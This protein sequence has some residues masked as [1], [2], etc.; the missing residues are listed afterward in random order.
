MGTRTRRRD[1]RR[2]VSARYSYDGVIYYTQRQ[3]LGPV[4][5]DT[6]QTGPNIPGYRQVI[7]RGGDATTGLIGTR[8]GRPRFKSAY[9]RF[10]YNTFGPSEGFGNPLYPDIPAVAAIPSPLASVRATQA[11]NKQYLSK[12]NSWR[13]GNFIAELR[14]TVQF[15]R[16]PVKGLFDSSKTFVDALR[17]LQRRFR[18]RVGS[19][20]PT[21][22]D[23]KWYEAQL[24]DLYLAFAFAARPLASDANDASKALANLLNRRSFD[25]LKIVATGTDES[26]D[27]ST[28]HTAG[29]VGIGNY[30]EATYGVTRSSSV[31]IR[32]AW[33]A[34]AHPA[35]RA[36]AELGLGLFDIVPAVWE[37][38]PFSFLVDY[39]ANVSDCLDALRLAYIDWAWLNR[40]VRNVATAT[41]SD[42]RINASDNAVKGASVS[43][44]H[45][46][47]TNTYV[48]RAK[49]G[50]EVFRKGLNFE[51]PG[52][53]SSR[54]LNIAALANSF[55]ASRP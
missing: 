29:W 32:G 37:A 51:I 55:L 54:W 53:G 41:V 10:M 26:D 24:S 7:A 48:N 6:R 11:F 40:T 31:T 38:I 42:Y 2:M 22:A 27:G 13:G 25:I 50:V 49:T 1:L 4:A 3:M 14:E 30:C 33:A 28:V 5:T 47:L 35:A 17:A 44:G 20:G 18:Y 34:R 12:A 19:R 16:N 8:I 46:V 52:M 21:R 9:Y 15:V 45:Y 39:F 23:W 43:G 36:P